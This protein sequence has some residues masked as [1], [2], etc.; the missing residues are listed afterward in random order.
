M[1]IVDFLTAI[2]KRQIG[3]VVLPRQLQPDELINDVIHYVVIDRTD[4][5]V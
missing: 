1:K 2:T 4:G 5:S 3:S